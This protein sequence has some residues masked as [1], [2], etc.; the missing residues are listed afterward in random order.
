MDQYFNRIEVS[1][2]DL[3]ELKDFMHP[4]NVF[5]DKFNAYRMGTLVDAIITEPEKLNI[6]KRTIDNYN[7]T[8]EEIELAKEMKRAYLKDELCSMFQGLSQFQNVFSNRI[9]IDYEGFVFNLMMRCKFDLW[10]PRLTHGADIKS[11]VCTTQKQFEE[12]CYHFDYDRQRAVYMNLSGA[13]KDLIIGISKKNMKIFK[14]PITRESE[15]FKSGMN[16]LSEDGFR[17]WT[18]FGETKAA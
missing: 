9:E 14:V 16:K 12:A 2:S 4:S 8:P 17:W 6:F 5:A 18:F 10:M 13:K 7:Y 3:G 15:F 1:N 11:T